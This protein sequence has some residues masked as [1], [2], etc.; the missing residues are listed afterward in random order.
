[1]RLGSPVTRKYVI[2]PAQTQTRRVLQISP[3]FLRNQARSLTSTSN[4]QNP[5]P[6]SS[7]K[8]EV[9]LPHEALNIKSRSAKTSPQ[10]SPTTT[11]HDL[12]TYLSHHN[13]RLHEIRDETS[14]VRLSTSAVYLGTRYEYLIQRH[15]STHLNFTLTRVGGKGDGGIDLIGAWTLPE[16][17]SVNVRQ[18]S[19]RVLCQAKRLGGNRKPGPV[20]MRELEG[21]VRGSISG[22][23]R[24]LSEA[25]AAIGYRMAA[26]AEIPGSA[27]DKAFT[28]ESAEDADEKSDLSHLPTMGILITTKPLSDGI[29][30]AMAVSNRPLMYM[31][32]EES[33]VPTEVD[34]DATDTTNIPQTFLR[35]LAWNSAA[36]QAGLEGYGV[37]RKYLDTQVPAQSSEV[38]TSPL[39]WEAILTYQGQPWSVFEPGI[40]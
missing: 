32:L 16:P 14:R 10:V 33:V 15:L 27:L 23:A 35:Q 29:E 12:T 17:R 1:M 31:C 37:D 34:S 7:Q 4:S 5:A 18:R 24:D 28:D 19:F 39:Q 20:L 21:T 3:L 30:K 6:T 38:I 9:F 11:H 13:S 26:K 25:F 8:V 40:L 2:Q 36:S 22:K